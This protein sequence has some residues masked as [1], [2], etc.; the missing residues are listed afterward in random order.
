MKPWQCAVFTMALCWV[1]LGGCSAHAAPY[2]HSALY[3]ATKGTGWPVV[4]PDGTLDSALVRTMAQTH[5]IITL[6][7]VPFTGTPRVHIIELLK[8]YNP[9]LKVLAYDLLGQR[10]PYG[11]NNEWAAE[12]ALVSSK[13]LYGT[14]GKL[15]PDSSSPWP[16]LADKVL[17]MQLGDAW[18]Y[19]VL[20]TPGLD[21]AFFDFADF[22]VGWAHSATGATIDYHR[23]GFT[24]MAAMDSARV[25]NLTAF[26]ARL[27]AS[28]PQMLFVGNGTTPDSTKRAL[29]D[30][31]M[32]ESWPSARG[33]FGPS[34]TAY[35][36][37]GPFSIIKV[38]GG[39]SGAYTADA[40]RMQR[41][42]L[43]CACM[44]DGYA[45]F[46]PDRDLVGTPTYLA[47]TYDERSVAG[48]YARRTDLSGMHSGWLGEK[49]GPAYTDSSG[50]LIRKF[51]HGAVLLNGSSSP[52][53]VDLGA[54]DIWYGIYGVRDPYSNR[55][56][57][58]Q[59]RFLVPAYDA[60][61]L[62]EKPHAQSP[63][64]R[65]L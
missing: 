28:Y 21:G 16:N 22:Y 30:G 62:V 53:W 7:V 52:R 1:L 63:Q 44:G 47:W 43:A 41:F 48:W 38:E 4:N 17:V 65:R 3:A 23:A 33:G 64:Q 20:W 39:W 13:L 36:A 54:T 10:F 51:P 12:W 15:F 55:G 60:V 14:D 19:N 59:R 29:W 58:S 11:G 32:F 34:M 46:G 27:R 57:D 6:N 49:A 18:L 25:A 2:P 35:L 37:A 42:G 45:C 61:F 8:S 9:K 24:T 50:V 26:F 5:D 40:C 31:D 56:G